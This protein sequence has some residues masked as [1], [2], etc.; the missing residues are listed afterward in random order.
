M[1]QHTVCTLILYTIQ[2]VQHVLYVCTY[3]KRHTDHISSHYKR[4]CSYLLLVLSDICS[5]H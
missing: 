1:Y 5:V 2:Y 3:L 4:Y